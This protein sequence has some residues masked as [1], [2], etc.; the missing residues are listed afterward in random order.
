ME[1]NLYDPDADLSKVSTGL[2]DDELNSAVKQYADAIF[3]QK[4]D[5]NTVLRF[6]P[7]IQIGISEIQARQVLKVMKRSL[8]IGF[9]S[10]VISVLA[11]TMVIASL[12]SSVRWEKNQLR[13]LESL[14]STVESTTDD[15]TKGDYQ[16]TQVLEKIRGT[17]SELTQK[18]DATN[19]RLDELLS[20]E[21]EK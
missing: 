10:F 5:I 6:S 14:V 4:G 8:A 9:V 19:A 15:I 2:S 3:Q 13:L 20:I 17:L 18:V 16:R 7:L 12:R 11:I 21:R 1:N